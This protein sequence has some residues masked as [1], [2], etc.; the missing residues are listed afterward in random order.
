MKPSEESPVFPSNAF[1]L[2]ELK[3]WA[4]GTSLLDEIK[5]MT[6]M[7]KL[8]CSRHNGIEREK[9]KYKNNAL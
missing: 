3:W 9:D 5:L 4:R 1:E 8:D 2:E 6:H 7:K